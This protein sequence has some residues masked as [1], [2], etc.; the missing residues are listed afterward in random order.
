MT[1]LSFPDL[2]ALLDVEHSPAV[3][4]GQA[5]PGRQGAELFGEAAGSGDVALPASDT[6]ADG[7]LAALQAILARRRTSRL[8]GPGSVPLDGIA[9]LLR[10]SLGARA[11]RPQYGFGGFPV[12]AVPSAGGIESVEAYLVAR[13]IAGLAPGIYRYRSGPHRLAPIT[14][15]G[16]MRLALAELCPYTSWIDDAQAL[17]ALVGRLDRLAWKY[18]PQSYRLVHLDAGAVLQTL[19]LVATALGLAAGATGFDWR[20]TGERLGLDEA[21][22]LTVAAIAIGQPRGRREEWTASDGD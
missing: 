3:V 6:S 12:R 22:E 16:S 14:T 20:A 4:L 17:V 7:E 2:H 13:D 5:R 8:F 9:A 19:Y 18:G 1:S 15:T 10:L 21:R 11:T